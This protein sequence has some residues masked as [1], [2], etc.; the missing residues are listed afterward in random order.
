MSA[1]NT[2]IWPMEPRT[3][4]KHEILRRYLQAWFPILAKGNSRLV[5]LDGFAGPGRYSNGEE[6][7]PIIAL[8][9]AR[10]Q[11]AH[12]GQSEPVFVFVE[13]DPERAKHLETVEVPALKLPKH[14][15]VQVSVGNFEGVMTA[16]LDQLDARNLQ[17]APTF[18]LIDPF[19]ITGIPMRLI[20]RLLK[21]RSCEVLITF[22]THTIQRFVTELPE[23]TNT[24]IGSADAAE[25]IRA[26]ANRVH[27]ARQLYREELGKTA[28]FVHFFSM[29]ST[30]GSPIYDLFF[31]TNHPLGFVRM[32]EAMWLVDRSGAFSL[33]EGTDPNQLTML[34]PTPE[35]HL[36]SELGR[37]FAGRKV[38]AKVLRRFVDEETSF[39]GSHLT[40]A[41]K[42]LESDGAIIVEA[43]KLDGSRRRKG[44]YPEG[45]TVQ[46]LAAGEKT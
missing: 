34:S 7:S 1:P 5:Y 19:G 10:A 29:Y 40:K 26:A 30:Q 42:L 31:A 14:F 16:L 41:L 8:Q 32:K 6:G 4:A 15:R 24:L 23:H 11:Y 27:T 18:A 21:R 3:R 12:L 37:A 17:L 38:G 2:T 9:A 46:F 13:E 36:A 43:V 44:T 35:L 20:S 33:H 22:M 45:A 39:I 25:K 28:R